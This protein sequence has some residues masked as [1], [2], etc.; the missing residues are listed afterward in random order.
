MRIGPID[1]QNDLW[2]QYLRLVLPHDRTTDVLQEAPQLPATV[3][4]WSDVIS[5]IL[6]VFSTAIITLV[7][8]WLIWQTVS[9]VVNAAWSGEAIA[10]E[11]HSVWG[12]FRIVFGL[13]LLAPVANGNNAAAL[14]G[15]VRKGHDPTLERRALVSA[16]ADVERRTSFPAVSRHGHQRGHY[17]G[18]HT[19]A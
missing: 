17:G 9:S 12:P 2:N 7:I 16:E 6:V 15:A 18:G 10:R 3:A 14:R 5:S 1:P 8:I 4:P 11:W 13:G 19:C